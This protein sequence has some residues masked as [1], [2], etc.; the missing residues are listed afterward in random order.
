LTKSESDQET[1]I[2]ANANDLVLSF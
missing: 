2:T 1:K